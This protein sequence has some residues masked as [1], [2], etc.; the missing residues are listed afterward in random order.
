MPAGTYI[1]TQPAT[2]LGSASDGDLDVTTTEPVTIT[3]AGAG[4]TIINPNSTDRAFAVASGSSLTLS[5]VTVANGVPASSSAGYPDGGAIYSR[6]TL[7]LS[8][9][10]FTTNHAATVPGVAYGAGG[11]IRQAS[12]GVLTVRNS[13]FISNSAPSGGGAVFDDSTGALT[14]TGDLFGNTQGGGNDGGDRGGAVYDSASAAATIDDSSFTDN[15]ALDHAMANS[16]RIY[17]GGALFLNG[18]DYVIDRDEFNGNQGGD[19]GGAILWLGGPLRSQ[20]TSFVA[21]AA[22]TDGGGA[23]S[24]Q[25]TAP[26]TLTNVT[27]SNNAA[28]SGGGI[29]FAQSTPVELVNDTLYNDSAPSGNELSGAG[30]LTASG[31]GVQNTLLGDNPADQISGAV[32]TAALPVGVD[33]GHNLATDGTCLQPTTTTGDLPAAAV[34]LGTPSNNGGTV[35]TDAEFAGQPSVDAGTNNVCPGLDARGTSRPQGTACDIGAFE[36]VPP[37]APPQASTTTVSSTTTVTAPSPTTPPG[38]PPSA[39]TLGT[40]GVTP[41]SAFLGGTVNPYKLNTSYSFQVGTTTTYGLN[42]VSGHTD[43]GPLTVETRIGG[44]KP[45]TTY[46]YRLVATS[47]AGAT[48]GADRTFKTA[49]AYDGRVI[50]KGATLTVHRGKVSLTL[51]CTSRQTCQTRVGLTVPI[52]LPHTHNAGTLLFTRSSIPTVSIR[53]HRTVTV[54]AAASA[55]ALTLISRASHHRL[56]GTLITRPLTAQ[57]PASSRVALVL[58]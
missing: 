53:A 34:A 33:L 22:D 37:P 27:M 54:S 40:M 8:S 5:G 45:G 41:N 30:G 15:Q 31:S 11:A 14:L 32:C 58:H 21:N 29:D 16:G 57:P 43:T 38:A 6:G 23:L 17:G 9:D 12:A 56:S 36:F 46:H 44:L 52:T 4:S 20:D 3:G 13:S 2:T 48:R 47:A 50:V 10:I 39:T 7:T 28:A 42:T 19:Y 55:A 51:G 25:T 49:P 18:H 35:L 26:L 1:F 24:A